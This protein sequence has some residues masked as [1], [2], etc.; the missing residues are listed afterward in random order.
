MVVEA[1][2]SS[3]TINCAGSRSSWSWNHSRHPRDEAE[4]AGAMDIELARPRPALPGG[5]TITAGACL[6]NP[7]RIAVAT[8]HLEPRRRLPRRRSRQ[9]RVDQPVTQILAA[10]PRH[11]RPPSDHDKGLAHQR[12][13]GN[14]D[15]IEVRRTCS[16]GGKWIKRRKAVHHMENLRLEDA[17]YQACRSN[18]LTLLPEAIPSL[19][20]DRP[21]EFQ[22]PRAVANALR[23]VVSIADLNVAPHTRKCGAKRLRASPYSLVNRMYESTGGL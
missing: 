1:Q 18:L 16:R 5:F 22:S 10:G 8:P 2:V 13:A 9:G 14:P 6:A 15:R 19:T 11:H 4:D 23:S 20:S 3:M 21:A 17:Q 12:R 7:A